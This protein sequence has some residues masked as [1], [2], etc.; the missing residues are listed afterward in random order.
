MNCICRLNLEHLFD[1]VYI[2][3]FLSFRGEGKVFSL[4]LGLHLSFLILQVLLHLKER[5]SDMLSKVYSLRKRSF[6]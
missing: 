1:S 6:C 3:F 4:T 2:L 5:K